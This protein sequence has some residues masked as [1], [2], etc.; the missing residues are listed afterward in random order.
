MTGAS[1]PPEGGLIA[2]PTA[3]PPRRGRRIKRV[4]IAIMLLSPPALAIGTWASIQYAAGSK[5]RRAIAQADRL[6]PGWRL[7]EIEVKRAV[8]PEAENS[9]FKVR[10]AFGVIPRDWLKPVRPAA[11]GESAPPL[12]GATLFGSVAEV[13]PA[14]QF[15]PDQTAGLRAELGELAGAVAHARALADMPR[16]RYELT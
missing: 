10:A 14:V 8:V 16:G 6:D 7:A 9:A 3:I 11:K 13:E 2:G 1:P 4:M 5:L 12:R 15:A